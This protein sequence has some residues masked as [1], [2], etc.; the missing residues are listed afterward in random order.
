MSCSRLTPRLRSTSS[1]V[2][3]SGFTSTYTFLLG[4]FLLP[5]M[6]RLRTSRGEPKS[7]ES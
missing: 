4:S 6:V 7:R 1:R 5:E 2:T 3:I